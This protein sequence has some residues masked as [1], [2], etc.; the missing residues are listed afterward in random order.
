MDLE[1]T[2]LEIE[3]WDATHHPMEVTDENYDMPSNGPFSDQVN[4]LNIEDDCVE[5]CA[6]ALNEL[7]PSEGRYADQINQSRITE[8]AIIEGFHNPENNHYIPLTSKS[9]TPPQEGPYQP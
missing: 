6:I 3:T 8:Q 1:D 5:N 7:A 2:L 4:L 9:A